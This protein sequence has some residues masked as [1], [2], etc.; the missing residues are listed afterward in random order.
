MSETEKA[1]S[2][3]R[4]QDEST[5]KLNCSQAVLAAFA[6]R[7]GLDLGA[8]KELARGFGGGIGRQGLTCG[9]VTGA[10]MALGCAGRHLNDEETAK[11][12]VQEVVHEFFRR[13]EARHGATDCRDLLGAD[14][15]TT[16][17]Y[18]TAREQKL[19]NSHCTEFVRDGAEIVDDLLI[20]EK[21]RLTDA[22]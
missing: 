13:F 15:S 7:L 12:H 20:R 22:G 1:L 9:A 19:F 10:V 2:F 18:Q 4:P 8:A 6:D 3:F 11:A 14:I 5:P 16:E 21:Q 17:G